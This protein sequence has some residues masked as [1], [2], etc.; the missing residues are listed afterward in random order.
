MSEFDSVLSQMKQFQSIYS[1]L[2]KQHLQNNKKDGQLLWRMSYY[3]EIIVS[4]KKILH[5]LDN[6]LDWDELFYHSRLV[7]K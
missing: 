6:T 7:R 4:C 2:E 1:E 5:A 3:T